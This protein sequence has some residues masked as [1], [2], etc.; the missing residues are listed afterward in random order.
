MGGGG[1]WGAWG[2]GPAWVGLS[3]FLGPGQAGVS[4]VA[5][6]L[7]SSLSPTITHLSKGTQVNDVPRVALV[8]CGRPS[9]LASLGLLC[10]AGWVGPGL[11]K[12]PGTRI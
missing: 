6:A 10:A 1:D 2:P 11:S 3:M 9:C 4:S 5:F 12:G 8:G 7:G